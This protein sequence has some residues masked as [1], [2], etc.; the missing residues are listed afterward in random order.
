LRDRSRDLVRNNPYAAKAVEELVQQTVGSGIT[1]RANTGDTAL[2]KLIDTEW[3]YFCEASDPDGQLDFYG[4]QA[5]MVRTT[6]ESGEGLARLRYLR[7]E[8]NMR[9]PLQLQLLESDFLDSNKTLQLNNSGWI[10]QGVEFDPIGR[11]RAYWLF[12]WHPGSVFLGLFRGIV[13]QAVPADQVLHNYRILRP[14]Q[15][16][17]VPWL[18]PV[19]MA[20]RDLDDYRDAERVRK[21]IEA[22][23][24]AFVTQPEAEAGPTL[25]P[26]STDAVSGLNVE[27]FEPGMVEYLKPGQDIK[28]NNPPPAGGYREYLT[29]ELQGI[30]SG[31]G[32]PHPTL[33]SDLSAV[34]YSSF[35]AGNLGFQGTIEAFRWITLIPNFCN[36]VWRA[37]IDTLVLTGKLKKPNYGVKWTSPKFQSVD[38][39]KD[40]NAE[41]IAIRCGTLTLPEAIAM[42]GYDPD[43]QLAE[44][45]ATNQKLDDLEI[46]LDTDPRNTN[47]RGIEQPADSGPVDGNPPKTSKPGTPKSTKAQAEISR[48]SHI[49]TFKN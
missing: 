9:V 47:I 44:I 25:G 1:P 35:R 36:P 19:M 12:P 3:P 23:V 38:P 49:R 29:T 16:R 22:C 27:S 48:L 20:L 24:A 26:R 46:I 37:F 41:K 45:A 15:V 18:A 34:N 42:N 8:D 7:A 13:S 39:L 2:D 14:G 4:Q 21:K 5:L 10:I 6:A 31:I 32:V 30:A 43:S 28:F 17:G 40:A 33:A 11:R